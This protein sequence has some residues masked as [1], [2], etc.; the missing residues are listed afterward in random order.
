[1]LRKNSDSDILFLSVSGINDSIRQSIINSC[2]CMPGDGEQAGSCRGGPFSWAAPSFCIDLWDNLPRRNFCVHRTLSTKL[3]SV[4]GRDAGPE[5]GGSN[6][7]A[8]ARVWRGPERNGARSVGESHRL[9]RTICG[10]RLPPRG[11]AEQAQRL[12]PALAAPSESWRLPPGHREAP[13][14]AKPA[15]CARP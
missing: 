13:G 7:A 1:M 2:E 5:T 8:S 14:T 6:H 9:G 10:I 15:S 12:A 3:S 11:A 4:A